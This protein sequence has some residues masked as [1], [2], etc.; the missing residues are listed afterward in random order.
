MDASHFIHPFIS[1]WTLDC[2]YF[3]VIM[4]DASVNISVQFSHSVVSDSLWPHRLQH[5][6]LAS[7]PTPGVYSNSC[8]LSRWCHPTISSS[9]VS[10]SSRLQSF[11]GAGSLPMSQFFSSGGQTIGASPSASVLPMNIQDWFSLGLTGLIS[12]QPKGLS[13][14]HQH[15]T[16]KADVSSLPRSQWGKC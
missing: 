14:P 10:F 4:N 9:V 15:V 1:W 12:F 7:I 8:P 5:T 16:A 13:S 6:R 11:P 3:W 2:F